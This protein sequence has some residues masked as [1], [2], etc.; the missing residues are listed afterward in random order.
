MAQT[1]LLTPGLLAGGVSRHLTAVYECTGNEATAEFVVM[2]VLPAGSMITGAFLRW[3]DLSTA[4]TCTMDLGNETDINLI[5]AGGVATATGT[6]VTVAT[7]QVVP[8]AATEEI[9]LSFLS[10]TGGTAATIAGARF[11]M[12]LNIVDWNASV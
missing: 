7:P 6:A 4:T 11:F 1:T 8:Q 5:L 9:R 10:L 12:D 2:G 3:E